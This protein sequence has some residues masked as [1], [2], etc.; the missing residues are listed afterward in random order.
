[1]IKY[2]A[3]IGVNHLGNSK[4]GF[5]LVKAAAASG[6]DAVSMQI[7][8]DK[9]YDYKKPWRRRIKKDFYIKN[10]NKL[11]Y[12]DNEHLISVDKIK[13]KLRY[14]NLLNFH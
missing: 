3:E 11:F 4:L 14:G 5:K 10:D 13:E 7:L 12:P 9:D 1:M 2:V 8:E 6:A